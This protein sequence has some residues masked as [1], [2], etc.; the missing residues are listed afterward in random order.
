VKVPVKMLVHP[1][2]GP[3]GAEPLHNELLVLYLQTLQV[4]EAF[5]LKLSLLVQQHIIPYSRE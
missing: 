1:R 2:D 3:Y 4:V 5:G